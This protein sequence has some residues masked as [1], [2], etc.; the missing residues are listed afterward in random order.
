MRKL[1]KKTQK[2]LASANA[3]AEE[4]IASVRTVQSFAAQ[5]EEARAYQ[6]EL[7]EYYNLTWKQ[8]CAYAVYS[9]TTFTFLPQCTSCLVLFYG[10]KLVHAGELKP[11]GT[12]THTHT[13]GAM[14]IISLDR[15]MMHVHTHMVVQG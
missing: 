7:H 4:A 2:A 1:S 8:A 15:H 12:H 13:H 14:C 6:A 5:A 3:V 9:S 10:G 11:G